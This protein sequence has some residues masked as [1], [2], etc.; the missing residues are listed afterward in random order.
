MLIYQGGA[1]KSS[2]GRLTPENQ[3]YYMV[4]KRLANVANRG[5]YNARPQ[6]ADAS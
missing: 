3:E 6:T 1:C 2:F 5:K 4:Y